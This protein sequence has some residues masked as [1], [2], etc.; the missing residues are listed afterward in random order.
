M[1]YL[2]FMLDFVVL[3]TFKNIKK[4]IIDSTEKRKEIAEEKCKWS[5]VETIWNAGQP[6]N[7]HERWPYDDWGWRFQSSEQS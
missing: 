6:Y 3:C 4:I 5:G 2:R 1:K 7:R